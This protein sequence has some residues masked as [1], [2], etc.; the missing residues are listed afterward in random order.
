MSTTAAPHA[1]PLTASRP[2]VAVEYAIEGDLRFLSHHDELRMLTRAL[3][4]SRWPLAYS[5]GFNPQPRL[6]I[7]LPRRTGVAADRQLAV[8]DLDCSRSA[9]ELQAA[10]AAVMPPNVPLLSVRALA[11]SESLH[12]E[13]AA[14][15]IEIDPQDAAA[16]DS[17]VA[18]AI[19][20]E[21]LPVRRAAAPNRP[22]RTFDL[23]PMLETLNWD[24]RTL[25]LTLA[26]A[27]QR[28]ARPSD[29]LDHLGLDA[30][31]YECRARRTEVHWNTK[32]AAPRAPAAKNER[33][34][35]GQE[36]N[37]PRVHGED[38]D[39]PQTDS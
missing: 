20:A 19:A 35:L 17:R 25:R 22:V 8:V 3:V 38:Q 29:V 36:N 27:D 34:C 31:L 2:R 33:N 4:R 18:A 7:P 21:A 16:L 13:R 32:S 23:R 28:S 37:D 12:A 24:G 14:F 30:A 26:I 11:Q 1:G 15:L 5:R 10:L 9:D 6:S 39:A